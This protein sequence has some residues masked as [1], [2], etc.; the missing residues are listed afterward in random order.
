MRVA[1]AAGFNQP[2]YLIPGA[3]PEGVSLVIPSPVVGSQAVKVEIR[4]AAT[5]KV[6]SDSLAVYAAG[7]G[8]IIRRILR[9][10]CCRKAQWWRRQKRQ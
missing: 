5:A 6:Q 3:M 9:W 10:W 4:A 7:A 8:R 2:V 1:V